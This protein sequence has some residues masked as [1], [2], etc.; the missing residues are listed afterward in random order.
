MGVMSEMENF[1]K[2]KE[3]EGQDLLVDV[4]GEDLKFPA[5]EVNGCTVE[6]YGGKYYIQ[7]D[8]DAEPIVIKASVVDYIETLR[9]GEEIVHLQNNV[10]VRI[11]LC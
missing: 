6:K 5:V 3:L 7:S 11:M 2:L 8:D 9:T 1:R 10:N 4:S